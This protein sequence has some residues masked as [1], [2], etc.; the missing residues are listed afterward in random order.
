MPGARC[1]EEARAPF[2]DDPF[3]P[4]LSMKRRCWAQGADATPSQ[5]R[6]VAPRRAL[7]RCGEVGAR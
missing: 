3:V 2:A 4:L 5:R 7:G 1:P 6:A